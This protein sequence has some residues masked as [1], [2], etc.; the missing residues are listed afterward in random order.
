MESRSHQDR[1]KFAPINPLLDDVAALTPAW[2]TLLHLSGAKLDGD[3]PPD[4]TGVDWSPVVRLAYKQGMLPILCDRIAA[5]A[6]ASGQRSHFVSLLNQAKLQNARRNLVLAAETLRLLAALENGAVPTIAFKG[7]VLSVAVHGNFASRKAG[8]IDLL[9]EKKNVPRAVQILQD[10]SYQSYDVRTLTEQVGHLT[11]DCEWE[12]I[13]HER[14]IGVDLHWDLTG[15]NCGP[16][17][18]IERLW[19]RAVTTRFYNQS[20]RAFSREDLIL[21]LGIH[22]AK[23][24]WQKW[25]WI[26]TFARTL[27]QEPRVQWSDLFEE[28]HRMG[29]GRI[30]ALGTILADKFYGVPMPEEVRARIN[31]DKEAQILAKRAL[32]WLLSGGIEVIPP[33]HLRQFL[34]D[35][36]DSVS[37]KAQY[38]FRAATTPTTKDYIIELPA[39]LHWLFYLIRGVRLLV[40]GIVQLF[41]K[42]PHPISLSTI[43]WIPEPEVLRTPH[44]EDLVPST[45]SPGGSNAT[46]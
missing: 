15:R 1:E 17:I 7:C 34:A 38:W 8:D 43:Q 13:N 40:L 46:G 22:A 11:Y 19:S 39:R 12:F 44:L 4:Y 41:R 14:R 9:V 30:L 18:P 37:S 33:S 5:E 45:K 6:G 32:K 42:P 20:I 21:V 10:C 36:R 24:Y 16:A 31:G 25:E 26:Y 3:D 29:A 23:H 2:N 27:Q 28:A 35:T